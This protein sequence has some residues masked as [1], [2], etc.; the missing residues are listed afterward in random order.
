MSEQAT[1]NRENEL[2][3]KD[4][5]YSSI[6]LNYGNQ[7]N[8]DFEN[9]QNTNF[10]E[11]GTL[12]AEQAKIIQECTKVD[13][14]QVKGR[15]VYRQA[16]DLNFLN[17]YALRRYES[18]FYDTFFDMPFKDM[19]IC[20]AQGPTVSATSDELEMFEW[21]Q[22]TLLDIHDQYSFFENLDKKYGEESEKSDT[23]EQKSGNDWDMLETKP[24]PANVEPAGGEESSAGEEK[25]PEKCSEQ[26]E[27]G[28]KMGSC[29]NSELGEPEETQPKK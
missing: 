22:R 7:E 26:T 23:W 10:S 4:V 15:K 28:A 14:I 13:Y 9:L 8:M 11:T 3:M 19:Q 16:F 29:V 5:N 12:T 1:M 21:F 18:S 6:Q 24:Q 27:H 17:R 20:A 2:T 25:M